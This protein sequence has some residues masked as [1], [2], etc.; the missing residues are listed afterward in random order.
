VKYEEPFL[1]PHDEAEQV[2]RGDDAAAICDALAGAGLG[3]PDQRWVEAWCVSLSSHANA[4]VRQLAATCL[5]HVAR[6]FGSLDA[7]SV[8]TLERLRLDPAAQGAAEDAL[9]DYRMFAE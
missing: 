3:D 9:G 1:L 2:F 7:G 4:E 6:R 8:V 5:G